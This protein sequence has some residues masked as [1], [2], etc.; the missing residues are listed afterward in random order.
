MKHPAEFRL[1]K[2]DKSIVHSYSGRKEVPII[3][4]EY[5]GI[6]DSD[7][8]DLYRSITADEATKVSIIYMNVVS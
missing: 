7:R 4:T 5:L 3:Y 2:V 1:E 8:A 6:I